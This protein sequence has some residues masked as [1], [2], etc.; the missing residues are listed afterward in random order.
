MTPAIVLINPQRGM[1]V[2]CPNC[3]HWNEDGS[4]FCEEC[5]HELKGVERISKPV[6]IKAAS[7]SIEDAAAVPPPPAQDLAPAEAISPTAYTG[8]RLVLS[9]G[10]SIFRL[11]E[12]TTI[13][14]EDPRLGIDFDG[15]ADSQYVSGMHAQ[16]VQMNGIFYVEDMGSSNHTYVNEKRLVLGQLEPLKTGDKIRFAKLEVTF[17]EA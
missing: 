1:P 2:Q 5:G 7:K 12:K 17:H 4:N 15:Y 3:S 16:I 10:G 6:S 9:N 13:G 14:R 8:A 11:G